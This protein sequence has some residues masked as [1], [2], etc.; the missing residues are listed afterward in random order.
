MKTSSFHFSPQLIQIWQSQGYLKLPQ[1][2]S[3]SEIEQIASWVEEI[4]QMKTEEVLHH[5]EQIGEEKRPSRTEN[6]VPRHAGMRSLLTEG[7]LLAVVSEA[8]GEPAVL[9]K[10]KINYKYPQGG[11]YAAHQDATA[12]DALS[13]HI[14][15]LISVEDTTRQ[16]G[17][18]E[19]VAGRHTAGFL[20]PTEHGIIESEVADSLSWVP[21]ETRKGDLL[22]FHSFTPHRSAPNRSDKPRKAI[23]ATY[24]A[25]AEGD[26]REQY[27]ENKLQRLREF[28]QEGGEKA[29]RIS[30]IGH[31]QGIPATDD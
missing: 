1:F 20:A 6:F 15:C 24:N 9:Y 31:F 19:M 12:Y 28:Q 2:F 11:G 22:L 8:L 27:Y 3:A 16:N 21:V 18:L 14:S 10:E 4:E 29:G 23:Y 5:Y 17:C 13:K 26:L 7:K 30:L 25:L